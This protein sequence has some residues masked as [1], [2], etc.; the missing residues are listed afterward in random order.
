MGLGDVRVCR[1]M[2]CDIAKRCMNCLSSAYCN[3]RNS[4]YTGCDA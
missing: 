3:I 4:G 1:E 2:V